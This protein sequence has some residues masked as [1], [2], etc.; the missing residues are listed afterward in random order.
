MENVK[1]IVRNWMIDGETLGGNP[2]EHPITSFAAIEFVPGTT[3]MKQVF[4]TRVSCPVSRR[5]DPV[6]QQWRDDHPNM[7]L[8][9]RTLPTMLPS[10]FCNK[11]V[12]L[13][14][15]TDE[16]ENV[17]WSK[18]SY[19]D[20]P[21]IVLYLHQILGFDI[22]AM[23]WHYRNIRDVRSY[24]EGRNSGLEKEGMDIPWHKRVQRAAER[25][26][27]KYGKDKWSHIA[28]YDCEFQIYHFL[29]D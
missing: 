24:I 14:G 8:Y 5:P 12:D 28:K 17:I 13:L 7:Y 9:E 27:K 6:T 22:F 23:P 26:N 15:D 19:F 29:E 1:P 11:I 25:M 21:F 20:T 2:A 4:E 10:E 3:K 18:P 16:V